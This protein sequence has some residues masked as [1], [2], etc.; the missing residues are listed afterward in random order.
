MPRV[1]LIHW[2]RAAGEATLDLLRRTG[3]EAELLIPKGGAGLRVFDAGPPDAFVID[4]TRSPSQG[5]AVGIFLRGRKST[6]R[7]PLIFAGGEPEKVELTRSVLPDAGYT[8]WT[9]IARALRSALRNAPAVPVAPGPMAEY[10]DRPLTAKLGIKAGMV[11]MLSGAPARFERKL[12]P[13]PEGVRL[14]AR[15]RGADRVLLF[16]RS[17]SD[18]A[19]RFDAAATAVQDGGGLWILWPK[20]AAGVPTDLTQPVVR[21]FAMDLGWVDYKICSVDETWSG[22]LFSRRG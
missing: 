18:L 1:V 9:G 19:G 16:A 6:R 22:L 21:R 17:Q 2:N 12:E 8:E 11:V 14:L 15:A 3:A 20:Q 5:R 10:R 13:L 7:V 4:L